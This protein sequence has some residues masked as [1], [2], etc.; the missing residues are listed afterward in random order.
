MA[1][2]KMAAIW[3]DDRTNNGKSVRRKSEPLELFTSSEFFGGA[4]MVSRDGST[5]GFARLTREQLL[6]GDWE[7]AHE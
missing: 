1:D 7:I 2:I 3:M 5:Y 6:A 4:I